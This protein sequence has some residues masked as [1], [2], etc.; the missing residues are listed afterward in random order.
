MN[1]ITTSVLSKP[2]YATLWA[3]V[4]T[5]L[6]SFCFGFLLGRHPSYELENKLIDKDLENNQLQDHLNFCTHL[7]KLM[8]GQKE[9]EA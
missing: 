9:R 2:V 3:I 6:S 5:N 1:Y 4:G 7:M 8:R